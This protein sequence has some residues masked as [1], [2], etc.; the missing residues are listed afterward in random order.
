M[1]NKINNIS[2]QQFH[3]LSFSDDG[4]SEVKITFQRD[5]DLELHLTDV[6]SPS[7]SNTSKQQAALS[8]TNKLQCAPK[9]RI[10]RK[11]RIETEERDSSLN[12]DASDEEDNNIAKSYGNRDAYVFNLPSF[13]PLREPG[14]HIITEQQGRATRSTTNT[15]LDFFNLFFTSELIDMM[16]VLHTNQ[17]ANAT[18]SKKPTYMDKSGQWNPT[19]PVEIRKLIGLFIYHGL[20]P[21][22]TFSRYW[23][24]KTL[25]H[26]LWS[27]SFMSRHR[28]YALLSMLHIVDPQTEEKTNKL[29]KVDKFVNIFKG[30]CMSLYQPHKEV[31][32]DE[33]IVKSKHRSG[34]RQYIK[35]KPIKFGI[36]LWVLAESKTGYTFNF[37]VYAGKN[38]NTEPHKNG[39]AYQVVTKLMEPLLNQ[40]YNLYFDNFYTSVILVK[41]LLAA[42]VPSCGT[43]AE[44]RKGFPQA[45]KGGKIW[46]RTAQRGDMRW[47]RDEEILSLQWKDNKVVTMLSSMHSGDDHVMV[48][49]KTRSD[50]NWQNVEVKQPAVIK[51]YN[52]F[53]NG[54]DKSDQLL[55]AYNLHRKCVRWWKTL[56]F[57]LIDIATVNAFILFKTQAQRFPHMQGLERSKRFS[58]LEF[59]E[60]LARNLA[61]LEEFSDPPLSEKGSK[62]DVTIFDTDHMIKFSSSKRNCKVCYAK[63]KKELKVLSYCS[64]PQ[65]NVYLHCTP[66]NN[67]FE[68]WHSREYHR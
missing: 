64:A 6:P 17:Y 28:F 13:T 63:S 56:F 11:R 55:S 23:S 48:T 51:D 42:G 49:R 66:S 12:L 31:A 57:H 19:T 26:G 67:C 1:K 40:G 53:M 14:P 29:R 45:M 62:K 20:V 33:R 37:D 60:E 54:V 65:C 15:A 9:K 16:I 7:S 38:G 58:V 41:D 52:S 59:R 21:V 61:Q 44:N 34:I 36:K 4:Q 30:H 5:T 39:L 25:Y 8:V 27:R 18:I 47:N 50:G 68:V 35:N 32:I 24:T 2:L 3:S 46:A 10:K 43:C 22:S